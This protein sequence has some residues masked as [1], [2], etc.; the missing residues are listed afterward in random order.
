MGDWNAKSGNN[1][2]LAWSNTTGRLS[3]K[4]KKERRESLLKFADKYKLL[5]ANTMFNH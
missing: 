5:L 2:H 4:S 3:N 1:G